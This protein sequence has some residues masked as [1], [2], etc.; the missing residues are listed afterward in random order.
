[1][2]TEKKLTGYP[3]IDKPWTYFYSE[4][5]NTSSLTNIANAK[6]IQSCKDNSADIH[7]QNYEKGAKEKVLSNISMK[8]VDFIKCHNAEFNDLPAVNYLGK[9][10][11]YNEV[12]QYVTEYAKGFRAYGIKEN[13]VVSVMLPNS[14]EI[15]Y[16][17][18][19]LNTIGAVANLID[20]RVHPNTLINY[21]NNSDSKLLVALL[22]KY[23]STI[24]PVLDK[25]CV[26]D[27]F[28]ISPLNSILKTDIKNQI[29]RSAKS[30]LLVG[31]YLY[32]YKKF[33]MITLGNIKSKIKLHYISELLI[34]GK[35]YTGKIEADY[36]PNYPATVLYTSGTTGSS[37][38]AIMSNESYN[39]LYSNVNYTK[40]SLKPGTKFCGT[41][42]FFSSYGSGSGMFDCMC[43]RAEIYLYPTFNP[44]EF[45]KIVD[46][47][48]PN[49][50]ITVPHHCD[51]LLESNK[52]FESLH[53]IILG[54]DKI[55]P[56]KMDRYKK[57]FSEKD[58]IV[59]YGETELLGAVAVTNDESRLDASGIP[60][61][62]CKVKIVNPDTMAEV[63][64]GTEGEI[65][66]SNVSMMLGYLK[67]EPETEKITAYDE[68]GNKYYGTGD[69]GFIT[70]KGELCFTDRYKRLMK[71][72]DGHQ[73][74]ANPIEEVITSVHG[75]K[76]C[77]VVGLQ[78]M[79]TSGVIPTAF[80]ELEE[81]DG[82][83]DLFV[84][85]LEEICYEKLTSCRDKA[86][87]YVFLDTMPVT[88]MGK[89]DH[90]LLSKQ[91]L[92]NIENAVIVDEALLKEQK[93][94]SH[95]NISK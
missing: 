31:H 82:N 4:I 5:S 37:K 91:K 75:V 13:D 42:P 59:G 87:A 47:D 17:K 33:A 56:S 41:I 49:T 88:D 71:R 34:K 64:I 26:Q 21:V 90:V 95:K 2:E 35:N 43:C 14:P 6:I 94:R 89:I 76:N 72:Q 36:I 86:L 52:K 81:K 50:V 63:P 11:S 84:K 38:G 30:K 66:I 74:N 32:E 61:P 51:M 53:Q 65:Y 22:D 3:S 79:D 73:V 25:L 40:I 27:V 85:R 46:R 45:V 67:N 54:G 15:I 18:L 69:K 92:E 60:F 39:S 62:T 20:P 1:M 9:S 29:N 19:A 78:Y 23:K 48:K 8:Y 44:D 24:K 57:H 55:L 68:D 93:L 83:I 80:V 7:C 12:F 10:I 58:I 16:V 28:L 77:C 70:G